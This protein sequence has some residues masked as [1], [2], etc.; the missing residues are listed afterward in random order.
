MRW[1]INQDGKLRTSPPPGVRTSLDLRSCGTKWLLICPESE[2]MVG[3]WECL[4]E[5]HRPGITVQLTCTGELNL[6]IS[7]SGN[8]LL[9]KDLWCHLHA[10]PWNHSKKKAV[11]LCKS[12]V[13]CHF[14]WL[15]RAN[16][17]CWRLNVMQ[18]SMFSPAA[19][20]I[21]PHYVRLITL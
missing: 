17:H 15:R 1:P 7:V 12:V 20:E 6:D 16:S 21:H 13:I 18:F 9:R 5:A 2:D 11:F 14:C 3:G 19:S 10:H 8:S 4:L